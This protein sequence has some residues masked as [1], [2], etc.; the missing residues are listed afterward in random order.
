MFLQGD[1]SACKGLV[2]GDQE[3][4]AAHTAI[5]LCKYLITYWTITAETWEDPQSNGIPAVHV[6][7]NKPA[8]IASVQ[9]AD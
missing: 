3:S 2:A 1:M 6:D 9:L 7:E 5:R 4:S 8:V